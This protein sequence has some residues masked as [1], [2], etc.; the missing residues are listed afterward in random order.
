MDSLDIELDNEVLSVDEYEGHVSPSTDDNTLE[1]VAYDLRFTFSD[2]DKELKCL[3]D[4]QFI[5]RCKTIFQGLIQKLADNGYYHK[6][7]F[8]GGFETK[9]RAGETCKAHVHLR[10]YSTR[11]SS[12]IRRTIK[13]FLKE[14][15]D[16]STHG[17]TALMFKPKVVRD[18]MEFLRYPLK[19]GLNLRYCGGYKKEELEAM[20]Q[21]AAD[22]Y[23]KTVQVNQAKLDKM[24]KSDTLFLRVLEVLKKDIEKNGNK[25]TPRDIYKE[26]L[27]VYVEENRPVN[28]ATIKGYAINAMIQLKMMSID[29]LL[30]KW[31]V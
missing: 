25:K 20:Y 19:Q 6:S 8:I 9:N 12:T 28:E 2:Q 31:G 5:A 23:L 15:Y 26:Y 29:Q 21:T 17:N 18:R 13:R 14:T 7:Q 30:D 27:N 4:K 1:P 24:D 10:F 11:I 16:Q 22:S 3:E